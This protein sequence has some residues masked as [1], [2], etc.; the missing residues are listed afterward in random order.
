[1]RAFA[2]SLLNYNESYL[3]SRKKGGALAVADELV[4]FQRG[5]DL[6][7]RRF[8]MVE[9]PLGAQN[10]ADAPQANRLGA[11]VIQGNHI[12][13]GATQI[14]LTPRREQYAG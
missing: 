8:L 7:L 9:N 10:L 13:D 4:A 5:G 1:M 3:G 14:G 12:F 6:I 11:F 2:F